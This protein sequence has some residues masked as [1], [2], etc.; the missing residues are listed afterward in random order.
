MG[1][2]LRETTEV[3]SGS[4]FRAVVH[5]R[6]GGRAE[7]ARSVRLQKCGRPGLNVST[8]LGGSLGAGDLCQNEIGF[9]GNCGVLTGEL[10]CAVAIEPPDS[11]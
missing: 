9:F 6:R 3:R 2:D 4:D 11:E 10:D 7:V 5:T 8:F 1:F